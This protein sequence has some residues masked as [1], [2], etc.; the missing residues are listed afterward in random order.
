MRTT[1][2]HINAALGM[3]FMFVLTVLLCVALFL[4]IS[5]TVDANGVKDIVVGALIP[6]IAI[7]LHGLSQTVQTFAKIKDD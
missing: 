7:S 6:V 2:L 1:T 5:E 3:S 4:L